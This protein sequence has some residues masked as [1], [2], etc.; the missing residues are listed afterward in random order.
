MNDTSSESTYSTISGS[1]SIKNFEIKAEEKVAIFDW[2]DTLFCTKYIETLQVNV[3][4]V[5]SF[6]ISFEDNYSYLVSELNELENVYYYITYRA[7]LNYLKN[8]LIK[9]SKSL[10]SQM[11]T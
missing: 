8:L 2:D 5:F 11:P 3:S 4:E 10:S 1:S 7:L 9:A 6:R